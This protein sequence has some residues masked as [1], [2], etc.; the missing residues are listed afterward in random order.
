MFLSEFF[1]DRAQAS[2]MTKEQFVFSLTLVTVFRI[3]ALWH[4][5][6]PFCQGASAAVFKIC[7]LMSSP[8]HC[9]LGSFL[10]N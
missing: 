2:A 5:A 6:I 7:V 1:D 9:P 8:L 4:P 3:N 10:D